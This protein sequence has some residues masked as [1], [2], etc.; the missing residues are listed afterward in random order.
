[1]TRHVATTLL[2][3]AALAGMTMPAWAQAPLPLTLDEA[4]A[5]GLASSPRVLEARARQTAAA[6]SRDS[7]RAL[8]GPVASVTSGYLRTNHVDEFA[9]PQPGGGTRVIFP[10]IPDNWRLRADILFPVWTGGRTSALLDAAASEV[11]AAEA[12]AAVVAADLALDITL[13]YWQ[14]VTARAALGVIDEGL[15]RTD[16]WVADVAARVDAG[17]AA[18]HETAQARAHQARQRVQ[19]IQAA[20]TATMAER[21]LVRL[22]G[23]SPGQTLDLVTPVDGPGVS[24]DRMTPGALAEHYAEA[25]RARAERTALQARRQAFLSAGQAAISALRPQVST[26][27]GIEPA[28]PNPRFVPRT[29]RWHTSWDLGVTVTWSIWDSG[30][31]RADRAAAL[32][33]AEGLAERQREFDA[34]LEVEVA[35]RLHDLE[36]GRAAVEASAEAVAAAAEVHRV[37]RVR[38]DAG[39]ATATEVLDAH[40][41]WLEAALERTRLQA[42]T[43]VAEARLHRALGGPRR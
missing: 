40:V 30:R 24:A 33:Q 14:V 42:G 35:Q 20:Q 11:A 9:V 19:R 4:V 34:R 39:V 5:R 37:M 32:A 26:F 8:A 28:R 7:R 31:A 13:A 23:L 43:R 29:N 38:Y 15:A 16:A 27:A 21:E 12:D 10:D 36:A 2:V 17:V 6:A 1:M 18:P 22:T 41:A 25:V 3:T